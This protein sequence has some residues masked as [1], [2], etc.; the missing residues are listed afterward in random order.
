MIL[1]TPD[2]C[3]NYSCIHKM[4]FAEGGRKLASILAGGCLVLGRASS[5]RCAVGRHQYAKVHG[6]S[7]T[8]HHTPFHILPRSHAV[9]HG[10]AL[11]HPTSPFLVSVPTSAPPR[12]HRANTSS[13]PSQTL[14]NFHIGKIETYHFPVILTRASLIKSSCYG[15]VHKCSG[16]SQITN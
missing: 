10:S 8:P 15:Y 11:H 9:P 14:A 12:T 13:P 5:M 2:Y 3:R 16:S 4:P 7:P 6:A 1:M